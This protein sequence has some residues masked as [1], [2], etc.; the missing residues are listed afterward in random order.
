MAYFCDF[1]VLFGIFLGNSEAMTVF[2]ES[3]PAASRS[4]AM[5]SPW[6]YRVRLRVEAGLTE[7]GVGWGG[8]STG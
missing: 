1:A 6:A 7:Q 2:S 8:L 4:W 5:W 3:E